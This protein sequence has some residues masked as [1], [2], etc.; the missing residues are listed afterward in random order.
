[1]KPELKADLE[2]FKTFRAENGMPFVEK[3]V[4]ATWTSLPDLELR[5]WDSEKQAEAKAK[6]NLAAEG[7]LPLRKRRI[8][9]DPKFVTVQD[10]HTFAEGVAGALAPL[11]TRITEIE[12][13]PAFDYTGTFEQGRAYRKGAGMTHGGGIW[14]ALRDYPGTPGTPNSGWV[15][16]VK[17]GRDGKGVR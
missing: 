7:G 17:R 2:Q 14:I 10:L 6:E 12:A 5:Y 9:S 16:A 15:L 11:I 13:R 8:A 3:F 4:P 1:M